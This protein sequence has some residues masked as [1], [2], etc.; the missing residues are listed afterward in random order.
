MRLTQRIRHLE[1]MD[2]L[3]H[4][5]SVMERLQSA[6]NEAARRLTGKSIDVIRDAAELALVSSDLRVSFIEKLA[7]DI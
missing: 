5:P 3:A 7:K 2:A 1:Q 4:P 6:L